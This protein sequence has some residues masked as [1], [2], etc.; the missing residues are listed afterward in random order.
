MGIAT[1]FMV[2]MTGPAL[3][4]AVRL[5]EGFYFPLPER[6]GLVLLPALVTCAAILLNRSAWAPWA[7]FAIGASLLAN[8]VAM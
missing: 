4:L 3:S 6:Y 1:V 8:A 7:T 5:S 2:F